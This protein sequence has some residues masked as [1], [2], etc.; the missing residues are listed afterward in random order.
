MSCELDF[1]EKHLEELSY[2]L[3]R[4]FEFCSPILTVQKTAKM[5]I[6]RKKYLKKRRMA[7]L[8]MW[9][10]NRWNLRG[11]LHHFRK[12]MGLTAS[13]LN[14]IGKVRLI[15]RLFREQKRRK[16]LLLV[17]ARRG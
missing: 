12:H 7:K 13:L 16:E 8:L 9:S 1:V 10:L 3:R 2:E 11:H 6:Y 5:F 15:Q 14:L 17:L 4:K